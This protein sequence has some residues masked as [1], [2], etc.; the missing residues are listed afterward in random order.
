MRRCFGLAYRT[1]Y[2]L[3]NEHSLY[4]TDEHGEKTLAETMELVFGPRTS[5]CNIKRIDLSQGYIEKVYGADGLSTDQAI[6]QLNGGGS[7]PDL[8]P[9]MS[10]RSLPTGSV[11]RLLKAVEITKD[12][13]GNSREL[14]Y[15][16]N[17]ARV[18]HPLAYGRHI[19]C[20]QE[21]RPTGQ[22][23]YQGLCGAPIVTIEGGKSV[24]SGIHF[25]GGADPTLAFATQVTSTGLLEAEN[26][27][28]ER[29]P[30]IGP[31]IARATQLQ[32][33]T[34]S[35]YVFTNTVHPKA[36]VNDISLDAEI[37]IVGSSTMPRSTPRT[38]IVDRPIKEAVLQ[39]CPTVEDSHEP[40]S[41]LRDPAI[42]AE[43]LHGKVDATGRIDEEV[44]TA[45]FLDIAAEDDR[46]WKDKLTFGPL[47]ERYILP[48]KAG[49]PGMESVKLNTSMGIPWRKK[50]SSVM[51]RGE[52]PM[53]DGTLPINMKPECWEEFYRLD[54]LAQSGTRLGLAFGASPKDELV[55]KGKRKVRIFSSANMYLGMLIRKYF[56][57]FIAL[58]MQ[59]PLA[60]EM[61]V[62]INPM[63]RE[64][65]AMAN[66]VSAM[67]KSR[68]IACDFVEFDARMRYQITR[69]SFNFYIRQAV[70]SPY[71]TTA[72]VRAM[73]VIAEEV[74]NALMDYDGTFVELM[75]SFP[76]GHNMT[77][78][79]NNRA[80][81]L[82]HRC[83]YY[84]MLVKRMH[85]NKGFHDDDYSSD[86]FGISTKEERDGS[87]T[88]QYVDP[89]L[90]KFFL[91]ADNKLFADFVRLVCYGDDM[92][93]TVA[94]EIPWYNCIYI[95]QYLGKYGYGYTNADKQLP[96]VPYQEW[97]EIDFLKRK[98]V[99]DEAE[100]R[101]L[102]PLAWTSI[103]KPLLMGAP[104]KISS[105]VD[106][107][108]ECANIVGTGPGRGQL[109]EAYLWG[110]QTYTTLRDGLQLAMEQ[111]GLLHHFEDQQLPTYTQQH[112]RWL[113]KFNE[114]ELEGAFDDEVFNASACSLDGEEGL[115][116]EYDTTDLE[117]QCLEYDALVHHMHW[118]LR[119]YIV[120]YTIW[121]RYCARAY[122]L[123][124]PVEHFWICP[125][126]RGYERVQAIEPVDQPS[127]MH[128]F[129]IA[130]N[131]INPETVLLDGL[132]W[133][134]PPLVLTAGFAPTDTHPAL[135]H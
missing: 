106:H 64:W 12:E 22:E 35:D 113:K 1:N 116:I 81:R 7:R 87:V 71:Y 55:K 120:P 31:S 38:A 5:G 133:F 123:T 27:M 70:K 49:V 52:K 84:A 4:F 82:L 45:A 54:K 59:D 10:P 32:C 13:E 95:A 47:K 110:P 108:E 121:N 74:C 89:R 50:K 111:T 28:L 14:T 101:W 115:C 79:T 117:L 134:G 73:C 15:Q 41:R 103:T 77:V 61:A 80:N 51:E 65:T 67:G 94:P 119:S 125:S 88:I 34:G 24:I 26:R 130:E 124:V 112:A 92:C 85:E 118:T 97:S 128:V 132:S 20:L 44:L 56:L 131:P 93:G 29:L 2:L 33:F 75:Q 18:T 40:P 42:F 39:H 107:L 37:G 9:Y 127:I 91:Y 78:H 62:G 96:T 46:L 30:T 102:A 105:G 126:Y 16:V 63:G 36:V 129:V 100:A 60:H 99:W 11:K 104:P 17:A 43:S 6:V 58:E 8:T 122:C 72:H 3:I 86:E 66:H 90:M 57:E 21:V 53:E 135:L 68:A 69:A 109:G 76:S 23:S 48:G 83:A 114:S 19:D 98:F 25:L